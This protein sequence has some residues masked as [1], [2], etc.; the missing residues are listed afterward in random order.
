LHNAD[1]IGESPLSL[2]A[3]TVKVRF[4][5]NA[6]RRVGYDVVTLDRTRTHEWFPTGN[7]PRSL[8]VDG[9]LYMCLGQEHRYEFRPLLRRGATED[10]LE[11][12]IREAIALKPERHEFRQKPQQ[13]VRFMSVTGG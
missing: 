5:P 12:A 7:N 1:H 2:Y 9:T 11:A 8:A 6:G 3:S 10:E 4:G 13:V